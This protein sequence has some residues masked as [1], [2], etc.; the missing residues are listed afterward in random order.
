MAREP[1][2]CGTRA[3]YMRHL[4]HGEEPCR[5]CKDAQNDAQKRNPRLKAYQRARV[6]A[7]ARLSQLYETAYR[8]LMEEELAKEEDYR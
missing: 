6:R 4:R 5:A 2:P 8:S 1:K 7:L 3:A